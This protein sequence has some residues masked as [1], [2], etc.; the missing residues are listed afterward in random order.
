M[1]NEPSF[2]KIASD[3]PQLFVDDG[4]VDSMRGLVRPALV[5]DARDDEWVQADG[6]RT[7]FYGMAGFSMAVSFSASCRSSTSGST[8]P[9]TGPTRRQRLPDCGPVRLRF[10]LGMETSMA[11]ALT[12]DARIPHDSFSSRELEME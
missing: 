8:R 12:N 1:S 3:V 4:I 10:R 6:Q 9:L 7:E 5:P 2:A 11:F